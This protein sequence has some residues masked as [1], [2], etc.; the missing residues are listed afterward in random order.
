MSWPKVQILHLK[1]RSLKNVKNISCQLFVFI[2]SDL[3]FRN[4]LT[5][6]KT[7]KIL[8]MIFKDSKILCNK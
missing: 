7:S 6:S 4:K 1:K 3:K 2:K 8:L 5:K